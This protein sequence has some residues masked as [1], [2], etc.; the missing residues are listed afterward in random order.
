MQQCIRISACH[1]SPR[2][3]FRDACKNAIEASV[4]SSPAVL[5]SSV[6]T[7]CFRIS[8]IPERRMLRLHETT[9][10]KEEGHE[11]FGEPR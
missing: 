11:Y 3:R 10:I 2:G 1:Y 4:A 5:T 7:I 6:Q 8:R 9:A